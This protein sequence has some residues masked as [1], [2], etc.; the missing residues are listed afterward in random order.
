MQTSRTSYGDNMGSGSPRSAEALYGERPR[1]LVVGVAGG[2]GSSDNLGAEG[3][4]RVRVRRGHGA[5]RADRG[6]IRR[7]PANWAGG[8]L[9]VRTEIESVG[10]PPFMADGDQLPDAV[11]VPAGACFDAFGCLLESDPRED[12]R[13]SFFEGAME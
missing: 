3:V 11:R 2:Y 5:V 1:P 4:D 9:D 6:R 10:A 13:G 12:A 8:F 7:S